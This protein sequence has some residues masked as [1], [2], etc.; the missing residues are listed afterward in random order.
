VLEILE[1]NLVGQSDLAVQ[2]VRD[3]LLEEF[4]RVGPFSVGRR[5]AD[6]AFADDVLDVPVVG[7]LSGLIPPQIANARL[8]A[9]FIG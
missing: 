6:R 4:D 9:V 1:G 2:P 5:L 8:L 3:T 7:A